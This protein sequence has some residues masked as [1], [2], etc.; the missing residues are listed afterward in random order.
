MA[1]YDTLSQRQAAYAE[2]RARERAEAEGKAIDDGSQAIARV[3][4]GVLERVPEILAGLTQEPEVEA[5][6]EPQRLFP[7][8]EPYLR[9]LED[10]SR[11]LFDYRRS[12]TADPDD[13]LA[14]L[15]EID[16]TL[17][18]QFGQSALRGRASDAGVFFNLAGTNVERLIEL[19]QTDRQQD[20]QGRLLGPQTRLFKSVL[21]ESISNLARVLHDVRYVDQ[22]AL[23]SFDGGGTVPGAPGQP[24]L[25]VVHGRE[26]ITPPGQG[27]QVIVYAT[28]VVEG[29]YV[30][31]REAE[32]A[33]A[34]FL[35][36]LGLDVV[37]VT[38]G[39]YA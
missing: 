28:Q 25:A 33:F 5:G 6:P 39:D 20:S 18:R 24:M 23:P 17:T 35:R 14:K 9:K 38:A 27:G 31:E 15:D 2:R 34:E 30:R 3:G 1:H 7:G 8:L 11:A 32:D 10:A 4:R 26:R 37:T 36:G 16:H 13:L 29:S 12:G 21:D 19:I 22:R